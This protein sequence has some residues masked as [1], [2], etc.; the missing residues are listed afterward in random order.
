MQ[1]LQVTNKF[2]DLKYLMNAL[3]IAKKSEIV[4][5][6][7]RKVGAIIVKDDVV[8]GKGYRVTTILHEDPYK[9]ITHHAEHNAI[10]QAGKKTKGA[11]L[12]CTLEPCAGRSLLPGAWEPPP[13]CCQLIFEAGIR[14][15]VFPKRDTSTGKGGAEYLLSKGV[16]VFIC[17]TD[18]DEFEKLM[19]NSPWRNDVAEMDKNKTYTKPTI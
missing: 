6:S 5:L 3:E 17:N 2:E 10:L 9:D 8:V 16:E 19:D 13:P 4:Q 1:E 14:R 11:T 15:V 12:Y 7:K 18:V